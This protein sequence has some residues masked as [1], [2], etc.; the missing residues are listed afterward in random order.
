MPLPSLQISSPAKINLWLKV[1]GK[2]ED[3]FHAIHTRM[4]PL[5]LSDEITIRAAGDGQSKLTCSDTSIPVDE[6][7]L[8]LKALRAFEQRTGIP[9]HW[10]IHLEKHI[11]HGA[12]LGGGSSNAAAILKGLNLLS[13][14]RLTVGDLHELAAQIGS[15]IP[16]FLYDQTCDASGRGELIEPVADFHWKLPLVL[17][18]PSFGI[19]TPWAYQ[20]WS[21]SKELTG[22]LYAPQIC[23]WGQMQNDLERP[24]FEKWTLLPTLKN[25]LLEQ[26]ETVAA[27]MS[28]SGSTMF[29]IAKSGPDAVK[30]AEKAQKMAGPQCWVQVTETIA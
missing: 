3:G 28:G 12:G 25:W 17:I 26:G 9:Q 1:L 19:P 16:F 23:A 24:V 15:D 20:R 27:L 13:G 29:A 4:C 8:A 14:N 21:V 7:N 10:H 30:L 11:P 2:R 5:R 18:K 6:N 22:V